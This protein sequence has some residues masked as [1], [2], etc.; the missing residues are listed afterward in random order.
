[1]SFP[2]NVE[3]VLVFMEPVLEVVDCCQ[4]LEVSLK[5]VG[6]LNLLEQSF[7]RR[8]F[9]GGCEIFFK[10]VTPQLLEVLLAG[11]D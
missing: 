4:L 2:K 8:G 1:M 11:H 3:L 9:V 7:S 5:V 10:G 6:S